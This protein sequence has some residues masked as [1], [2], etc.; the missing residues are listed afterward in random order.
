MIYVVRMSTTLNTLLLLRYP[1]LVAKR[2]A[3]RTI[4]RDAMA[5][6]NGPRWIDEIG[7]NVHALFFH[8][9]RRCLV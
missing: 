3:G 4:G 5:I 7:N 9:Q 6:T 2:R 1:D 8:A